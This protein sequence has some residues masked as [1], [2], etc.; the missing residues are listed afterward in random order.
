MTLTVSPLDRMLANALPRNRQF[1]ALLDRE[2]A[3]AEARQAMSD[4]EI[5][6]MLGGG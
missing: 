1:R 3:E 4:D 5:A 2:V 6:T